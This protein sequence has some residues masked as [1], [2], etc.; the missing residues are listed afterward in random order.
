MMS[1]TLDRALS[2][3]EM[4][5]CM[6]DENVSPLNAV[7][8]RPRKQD[9]GLPDQWDAFKMEI[10]QLITTFINTQREE[11][12]HL[13]STMR[14]IQDTNKNIEAS[15]A[16]V[17]AQNEELTQKINSLEVRT[18]EDREYIIFKQ[19]KIEDLQLAYRK[20]NF[21]IKGVPKK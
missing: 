6:S 8:D 7:S 16:L 2:D 19:D 4:S 1:S 18:M 5:I 20:T 11:I 14:E 15:L 10:R 3:P 12:R 13:N 9:Q 21:E 17:A